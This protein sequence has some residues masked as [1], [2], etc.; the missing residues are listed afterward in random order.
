M[1]EQDPQKWFKLSVI[2]GAQASKEW[3]NSKLNEISN[4]E[5]RLVNY[6]TEG[7]NVVTYMRTRESVSKTIRRQQPNFVDP[8]GKR[9]TINITPVNEPS[10]SKLSDKMEEAIKECL[11]SRLDL[12]TLTLNL[13]DFTKDTHL[14]NEGFYLPLSRQVVAQ[15]I[16]RLL[17]ENLDDVSHSSPF[18]R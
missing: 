4:E 16:V 18:I 5:I 13:S 9:L 10:V 12:N 2:F 3:I 1:I 6:Q 8:M 15:F 17:V 11:K 14:M 7:K